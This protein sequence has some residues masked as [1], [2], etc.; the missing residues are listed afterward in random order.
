MCPN[1]FHSITAIMHDEEDESC[2]LGQHEE[3]LTPGTGEWDEWNTT[4][5]IKTSNKQHWMLIIRTRAGSCWLWRTGQDTSRHT[6]AGGQRSDS[7]PQRFFS[8]VSSAAEA[9][10]LQGESWRIQTTSSW[11]IICSVWSETLSGVE[12]FAEVSPSKMSSKIQNPNIFFSTN[13]KH[14]TETQEPA[15][16]AGL[17]HHSH[18]IDIYSFYLCT[19]WKLMH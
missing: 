19:L 13:V 6:A 17:N 12:R 3:P 15:H 16:Y 18:P 9:A 5:S 4:L 11:S 8:T 1:T 10:V 14:A 2:R 7:D